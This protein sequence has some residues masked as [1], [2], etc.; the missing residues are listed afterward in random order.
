M[1]SETSQQVKQLFFHEFV[2][3]E[4]EFENSSFNFELATNEL[5]D[6][7]EK[8]ND[9]TFVLTISLEITDKEMKKRIKVLHDSQITVDQIQRDLVEIS[10]LYK[11]I[12]SKLT[13]LE[14]NLEKSITNLL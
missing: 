12:D 9:S 1:D 7:I 14:T 11:R 3:N 10:N 13:K 4:Q 6:R 5:N 2:P 8:C